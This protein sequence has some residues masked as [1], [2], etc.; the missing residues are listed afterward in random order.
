MITFWL[1]ASVMVLL[2][3]AVVLWP[4]LRGSAEGGTAREAVN[5][6]IFRERLAELDGERQ[7]GRLGAEPY[8][9]LR[10]EL[11]RTLLA[12]V[13]GAEP[14]VI[15]PGRRLGLAIAVAAL[16]PLLM[17][18][19]YYVTS[20]R[21]D[22][23]HWIAVRE[24]LDPV[25]ER[26]LA[27]PEANTEIPPKDLPDFIRVLQARVQ[28]DGMGDP[29]GL[30]QLGLGYLQ[31]REPQLALP[32]LA[33]AHARVPD[34]PDIMLGYAEALLF[35]NEGKLEQDSGSL[36]RRLLQ[37][38]PQHQRALFLL[39]FGAFNS[40]DYAEAVRSW[41][42]LLALR[43]PGA[44]EGNRILQDSIARA[45][46]KLAESQRPPAG[47]AVAPPRSAG[48]NG[49]DQSNE[50]NESRPSAVSTAPTT[51][52][53]PAA[54][55]P[56]LTVTVDLAPALRER[57]DP[58]AT[59]FIFAKAA[60][61]PS[62]PLA[63]IRQAAQGFPVHVL[64]DDRLAMNPALKLSAFKQVI[65][66]ARISKSGAVTAQAGDLQGASGVLDVGDGPQPVTLV[67]DQVVE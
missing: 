67:I 27:D 47:A 1:L 21:G 66:S 13:P 46:Q 23:G 52:S 55:G 35:A 59:L 4:L 9:A 45:E 6:A 38:E 5:A 34:Q 63:A 26:L 49:S 20:Y 39:G 8:Q 48:A 56:Q 64:L 17:L 3:G 29:E 31:L 61:G 30:Y 57:L 16:L 53:A 36:L 50:S 22:A 2:A 28:N 54:P 10:T 32:L 15:V 40:G 12:D 7:A 51:E 33:R 24:R 65:V 14:V 37:L 62:P 42:A 60:E 43:E 25:V 18:G 11:E 41:R 58:G 44:S 19:Y